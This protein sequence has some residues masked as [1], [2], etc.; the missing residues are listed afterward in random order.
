MDGSTHYRR[1]HLIAK[2]IIFALYLAIGI[3]A[4]E[5]DAPYFALVFG[6]SIW[7]FGVNT[8]AYLVEYVANHEHRHPLI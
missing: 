5:W 4:I 8:I 3:V 1:D 6:T 7:L 2:V